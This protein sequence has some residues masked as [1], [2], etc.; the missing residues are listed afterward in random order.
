MVM[1]PDS[2]AT[3]V[4]ELKTIKLRFSEKMDRTSAVTWLHFFPDQ[5]IR[6]TKWHGAVEAEVIL[7]NTL[8]PDTVIVVEVASGMR[9]AHKVKGVGSRR[10]PI[11][12]GGVI[13]SGTI[14][15]V[16]IMSDSAVTN[17]VLELY[18]IPPDTLEYFQQP[19]LRRTVTDESGKYLFDWLPVPGGPW[20]VRAFTDPDDNLRPGEKDAQRLLPDTLSLTVESPTASPGVATLF[21][22]NTPGRV[23]V[24]P[25]DPSL[26][27]GAVMAWTMSVTDEDTGWVPVP[28]NGE[29]LPFS[30]L[31]PVTGGIITDVKPGN[32][33]AVLFVDMDGDSTFSGIPDTLLTSIP[34]SLAAAVPDSVDIAWYLEPWFM[35]EGIEVDPGLDTDFEL[36]R[37]IYSLTPWTPPPPDPVL[38]DSLSGD[39]SATAAGDSLNVPEELE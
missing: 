31:D 28:E 19:I 21:P 5:R 18:E 24:G 32:S 14:D 22:W 29:S 35:V 4:G 36:P 16:L 20:L 17:G 7:E 38:P 33:R 25:F 8:T 27:A 15:G 34:D 11:S 37:V 10:F 2:G 12:T 23:L 26:H 30:R 6:Q 1:S 13:P 39:D 9:D 3:G